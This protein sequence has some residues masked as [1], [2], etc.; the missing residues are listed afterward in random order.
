MPYYPQTPG[1]YPYTTATAVYTGIV[2]VATTNFTLMASNLN[3]RGG[4]IYNNATVNLQV[5]LGSGAGAQPSFIMV[6]GA[7]Y[8][9][10]FGWTGLVEG[11]WVAGG[12]GAAGAW[13]TEL[14]A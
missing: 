13:V 14:M 1:I 6:P 8:E 11:Y 3:R 10:P 2:Y 9:I 7:Y 4:L 12:V 5:K